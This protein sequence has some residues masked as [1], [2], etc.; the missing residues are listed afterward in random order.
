MGICI[1]TSVH[2]PFDVRIFHKQAKSLLDAGHKIDLIAPHS[3]TACVEGIQIHG[4]HRPKTRWSRFLIL[5]W[6]IL[7]K[8]IKRNSCIYHFHDPELIPVG[9]LL[10]LL[11]KKVVYDV[12]EDYSEDIQTKDWIPIKM[13]LMAAN[14]IGR[15]EKWSSK[16]FDGV[17]FATPVIAQVFASPKNGIIIQ[18]YPDIKEFEKSGRS[19]TAGKNEN[20]VVYAGGISEPRGIREMIGAV[21]MINRI[22]PVRLVLAGEFK[23]MSLLHKLSATDGWKHV[24]YAGFLSRR[25]IKEVYQRA[26]AGLV[27]LHPGPNRTRTQPIKLFEYMAA[28][29]PVIASDFPVWRKYIAE[30]RCGICVNPQDIRA[31]ADAIMFMVKNPAEA[32]EMGMNGRRAIEKSYNWNAESGKLISFYGKLT[33]N[34]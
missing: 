31:I 10:K 32:L 19:G 12:H 14:L 1:L 25:E 28:G 4:V 15:F 27:V 34:K 9:L 23:P 33:E 20:A 21:E 16:F 22:T 24:E 3:E 13:R 5:S 2:S 18:N 8:A 29:I 26:S 7:F 11:G 30:A 6:M 17:I